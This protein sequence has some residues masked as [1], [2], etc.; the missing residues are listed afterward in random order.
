MKPRAALLARCFAFCAAFP[1]IALACGGKTATI[2]DPGNGGSGGSS[3]STSG[4]SGST[5]GGSTSSGGETS[6]S[7]TGGSTSGGGSTSSGGVTSST[8]GGGGSS[9]GTVYLCPPTLPTSGTYCDANGLTCRDPGGGCGPVCTCSNN[10]W[11]CDA[12]PCPA[13]VCPPSP[14]YGG[15]A[16]S[17]NGFTCDGSNTNWGYCPPSCTCTNGTWLCADPSCPPPV[18]PPT[19]PNEYSQCLAVGESCYYPYGCGSAT[20]D[21][22]SPG[23]WFC[24]IG[25]CADAGVTIDAEGPDF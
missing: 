22:Q 5:S 1:L 14:P 23:T 19:Q 3:G 8:S 20:C 16:C 15:V 18:C 9:S 17:P 10:T 6:S 12:P 24:T 7:S 2:D 13:P 4:G 11:V 21:C 25:D